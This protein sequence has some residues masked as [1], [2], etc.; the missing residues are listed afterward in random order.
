MIYSALS[1]KL[2]PGSLVIMALS[3]KTKN[4]LLMPF[5]VSRIMRFGALPGII[6]MI[7]LG[8]GIYQQIAVLKIIGFV[9]IIPILWVYFAIMCIYLPFV[10]VEK[11]FKR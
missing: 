2:E 7:L 11:L 6:G 5:A 8:I 9:L 4:R 1:R 3:E 10:V